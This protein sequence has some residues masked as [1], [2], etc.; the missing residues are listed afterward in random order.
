MIVQCAL[1]IFVTLDSPILWTFP[2]NP[3]KKVRDIMLNLTVIDATEDR[4]GRNLS[5]GGWLGRNIRI[6]AP[7]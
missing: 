1:K 4:G 6:P 5:P 2:V 3:V 7:G